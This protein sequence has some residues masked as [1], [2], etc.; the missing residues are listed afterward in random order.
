MQIENFVQILSALINCQQRYH[1]LCLILLIFI[2][3]QRIEVVLTF[4]Y[5]FV[6]FFFFWYFRFSQIEFFRETFSFVWRQS[7]PHMRLS[8]FRPILVRSK[9]FFN[10]RLCAHARVHTNKTIMRE[11]NQFLNEW[12]FA[13][14]DLRKQ[15]LV[16]NGKVFIAW[17]WSKLWWRWWSRGRW[18]WCSCEASSMHLVPKFISRKTLKLFSIFRQR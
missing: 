9:W 7:I 10:V 12:C 3:C 5:F 14:H 13:F 15:K 4:C 16:V 6:A 17:A 18:Y 8:H 11:L 1:W 2:A